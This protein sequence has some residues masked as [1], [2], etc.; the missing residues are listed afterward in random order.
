MGRMNFI[1]LY[2]LHIYVQT[3][4]LCVSMLERFSKGYL[5]VILI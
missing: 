2:T 4:A 5:K 3:L 1:L